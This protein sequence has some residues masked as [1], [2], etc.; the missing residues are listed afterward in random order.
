MIKYTFSIFLIFFSNQALANIKSQLIESLENIENI[1]FNFEQNI[2]GKI[3]NGKCVIKYPKK[4]YC[5]YKLSNQ[6]TLTSNGKSLAIKTKTSYFIYPLDKTPLNLILDKNF[7]IN[8]IKETDS[9]IIDK[10]FINFKFVEDDNEINIFFNKKNYDLIG[11]QTLDIYQN[12]S[13][14][15]LSKIIKNQNL[16]KNLFNLPKKHF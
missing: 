13:I 16:D 2:N 8:K 15:Y 14:T 9:R 1:S 3:E 5:K 10:K 6:K 7:L 12:L 4:I 11:W